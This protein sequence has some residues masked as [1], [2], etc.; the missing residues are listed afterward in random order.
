MATRRDRLTGGAAVL[1][2]VLVVLVSAPSSWY[3]LRTHDSYVFSPA[4]FSPLWVDRYVVP[5]LAV[6]ATLAM[7]AGLAGLVAR[8]WPDYGRAGRWGG[9]AGVVG[10]ALLAVATPLFF[11]G[12]GGSGGPNAILVVGT[13]LVGALGALVLGGGLLALGYAYRVGGRPRLASVF[14]A[15]IVLPPLV[16]Y[17][18]PGVVKVV[19]AVVPVG[20]LWAAVGVELL[21]RWPTGT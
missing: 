17:L 5:A 10:A 20:L 4:P 13:L 2:G 3:G 18:M 1:G 9:G 21:G 6:V 11:F 7:L 12:V 19:V 8:D 15:A 16:G 14:F